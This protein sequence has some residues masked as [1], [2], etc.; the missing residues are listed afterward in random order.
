MHAST[1]STDELLQSHLNEFATNGL[2]TL[3]LAKR[4]L[5]KEALKSFMETW[6]RA[7]KAMVNREEKLEA[8]AAMIECDFTILGATAIEDK[9]QD[10]GRKIL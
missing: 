7:E 9:L 6:Q 8:A 10:N 5:S 4:H 3:I 1:G 2:R